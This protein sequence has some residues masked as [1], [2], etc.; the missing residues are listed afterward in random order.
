MRFDY[1]PA[2]VDLKFF[3]SAK[4]KKFFISTSLG[5]IGCLIVILSITKTTINY[6]KNNRRQPLSIEVTN[7]LHGLPTTATKTNVIDNITSH[8]VTLSEA[9]IKINLD[10]NKAMLPNT[11]KIE[12]NVATTEQNWQTVV[13]KPGDTLT[14]ILQD[15]AVPAVHLQDLHSF[16]K[17][18]IACKA[19]ANIKPGQSIKVLLDQDNNLK[20]LQIDLAAHKMLLIDKIG[21]K[22][23]TIHHEEKPVIK[24]LNF[25]GN[26]IN[27]SFY[28]AAQSAGLGEALIMEIADIFGWDIDFA[29]DIRPSDS[30][31][32]VYEEKFVENKKIGAGYILAAEFINQGKVYQAVRFTD[33][34]GRV[35]YYTPEGDSMSKTFIRTPVKFTR[36]GSKFTHSRHHPILHLM[37]AHKGVDYVAPSGTPVKAAGDG[38]VIAIG[39]KGGYGNVVELQHGNRYST[40]YAH[41][42]KFP[43]NLKKDSIVKQGQVIGYVGRT[44][45]ATGDHLHY[46][47]R[48]D[49]V[50][51][52]PLTV[53][54]PKSKPVADK[55]RSKFLFHA[56]QMINLLNDQDPAKV[57]G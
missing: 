35:D 1:Q 23:Y 57:T 5:V 18:N 32:I 20:T 19:I 46:E 38:R 44:G 12:D 39:R 3:K 9:N 28:S 22:N 36:I 11:D 49:G 16:L 55:Y 26:V 45:L 29:M 47:F 8:Q 52:D 48:V 21:P 31:R 43:K 53:Q 34:Q 15:L 13:I 10:R 14:H 17:T 25:A 7:S 6:S 41:L 33:N 2:L 50:H 56:Q 40:L 27:G 30:F 24:K 51:R 37:R 42:L 4:Q 54:F